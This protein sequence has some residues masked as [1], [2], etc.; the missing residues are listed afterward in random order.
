[1]PVCAVLM[2]DAIYDSVYG[3]LRRSLIHTSAFSENGLAMGAGLATLDVL[4]AEQLGPRA[5]EVGAKLCSRLQETLRGYEM[6]KGVRG[7]GL[8]LGIEFAA[9][10]SLGLRLSFETFTRIQPA[11]FGKVL[12]MRLFRDSG[13]LTQ[14]C[15]NNFMVLK[16]ASPSSDG[17]PDR[18]VYLG[19]GEGGGIR[20]FFQCLLVCGIGSRPEGH[21]GL[22]VPAVETARGD[23][24]S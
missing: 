10:R 21:P 22:T 23:K 16:G 2:T 14:I 19:Y 4:E 18:R 3:S 20:A 5:I 1:M 13:I 17:R 9:P 7:E 8:L 15:G 11:M 24:A 6:V 12:V